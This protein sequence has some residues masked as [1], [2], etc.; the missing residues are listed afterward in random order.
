MI[1]YGFKVVIP[2]TIG[3]AKAG[4]GKVAHVPVIF[5]SNPGYARLPSRF[6]IDRAIGMWDPKWRGARPNPQPPSRISM[7][8]F[9]YWLC[10]ALEWAEVRGI[11]LISADYTLVLISR[12]QEEMLKGIW[13]SRGKPLA[14]E[15]VNAR[16][17]IVLEYQLW[18]SDKGHREPFLI[19][20]VTR[21][22]RIGRYDQSYSHE[23]KKVE[24]RKG[25]IKVN[26]RLLVFPRDEEIKIWRQRILEVADVGL[27]HVLM[28]DHILNTAIRREELASWRVDTLPLDPKHWKII[29]PS[30]PDEVQQV[31]IEIQFGTKGREYYID[32]YGDKVGPKGI[33]L[34]PI[35]FARR[36][37]SYRNNERLLA[38]KKA[39]KGVQNLAKVKFL[40]DQS[41]HLYLNPKTGRR[42]T[43]AQ[44]YEFWT[45]V[46][47]PEHW[48]PHLGRDWWACQYLLQK[49][50]E[51]LSLI[52]QIRDAKNLNIDHPMIR[53]LKDT[54]Q[55]VIHLEIRPQLRH[56]SSVTTEIYLQ[57]LFNQ[58]R[59]PLNL[60]IKWQDDF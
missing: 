55:T 29:N 5:D 36:I 50:Q 3:L 19:P 13:S 46:K 4:F 30:Q 23:T 41:V 14:A 17:Q 38:L 49:I 12:Y 57:W 10:N 18:A 60:S 58:L 15:T 32:E 21:S 44:I 47:G 40:L 11:D 43:G 7:R 51:H 2:D 16:V 27:T 33:I 59:L 22:Y 9:A 26:K 34:M 53:S 31:V 24:S 8:N 35:S 56:V 1:D 6:L 45:K 25:K 39:T 28:V 54:I 48:S 42:Y 52:K 37:H 20:T